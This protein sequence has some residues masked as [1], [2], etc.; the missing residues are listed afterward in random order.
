MLHVP[1]GAQSFGSVVSNYSTQR[2]G[3]SVGGV[4]TPDTV[5]YGSWLQVLSALP[6]DAYGLL[7]CASGNSGSG[8][9]R[10]TLLKVGVDEAGGTSY[11]DRIPGLLC[12]AAVGFATSGNGVWYYFPIFI[13]AGSTVAV[14]A[15]GTVT[16]TFRVTVQAFAAPP[17]PAMMR[18][19]SLVEAIGLSGLTGASVTP[20]TTS[21]GSWTLIGTTTRRLWW[22][23]FGLHINISDTAFSTAAVFADIAVGDASNKDIIMLDQCINTGAAETITVMPFTLGCEWDVPAGSNMYARIQDGSTADPFELVIYGAG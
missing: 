1:V 15:Y 4:V 23:Q 14:A 22:W 11:V 10:N 2:P 7:I 13:P 8:A 3:N 5:G 6:Y 19:A 21:E 12:G 16:T 18:K 17:N 20:G 9:N